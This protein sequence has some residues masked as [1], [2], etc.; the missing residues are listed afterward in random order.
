MISR[1]V[2]F[3][4]PIE[5]LTTAGVADTSAVA[6]TIVISLDGTNSVPVNT[7][8]IQ[9]TGTH[10]W[11]VLLTA[12]EMNAALVTI[13]ATRTGDVPC[14]RHITTE[15]TYEAPN[16][17]SIETIAGGIVT[18]L[19]DGATSSDVTTG[20][21]TVI[22]TISALSDPTGI[23]QIII[24]DLAEVYAVSAAAETEVQAA[25][26]FA[27]LASA[28]ETLQT[29][30]DAIDAATPAELI[31]ARN[32]IIIALSVYI[33]IPT[34]TPDGNDVIIPVVRNAIYTGTRGIPVT[35]STL[36]PDAVDYRLT[37]RHQDSEKL[38]LTAAIIPVGNVFTIEFVAP[39]NIGTYMWDIEPRNVDGNYLSTLAKGTLTVID[40]V[41][42]PA[43][44]S[45][46]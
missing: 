35:V 43:D 22:D 23:F 2:S 33:S 46:G 9:I 12:A 17:T 8:P 24:D 25:A 45:V 15:S 18:L 32:A 14:V 44:W 30:T 20:I 26:R 29:T 39:G 6:P 37:I 1:N 19:A 7:V 42:R 28:L 31:A 38:Y 4:C 27:L 10:T 41:T 13:I 16:N 36:P 21:Q 3:L 5:M 11:T 34:S 40:D